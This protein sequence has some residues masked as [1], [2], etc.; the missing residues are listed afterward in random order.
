[1]KRPPPPLFA[2]TGARNR[3]RYILAAF[4]LL[5]IAQAMGD[6]VFTGAAS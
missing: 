6:A 1:M 5:A 3:A 4:A 2:R